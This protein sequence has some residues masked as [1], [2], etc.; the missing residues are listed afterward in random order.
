MKLSYELLSMLFLAGLLAGFI[1]S[2]AGGGG[3]ISLP[4]LLSVG[5]SPQVALGTNK[6]QGT[7]GVFTATINYLRR[8]GV[9][10]KECWL[11]VI[12]TLIGATIGSLTVQRM[13]A[14]F[15]GQLV[16]FLLLAV[17]IYTIFSKNLGLLSREA[18]VNPST[19]FFVFGF[20]LGF[21]D[22][23]F[24]PGTGAFWTA[25]LL[26]LLGYNFTKAVGVTKVMN[27]T[28]NLVALCLFAISGNVNIRAGIVMAI[29]QI[30]G[31]RIGSNMA[32]KRGA[33][34][35]R[36]VFLTIVFIT[37]IRLFY[38]NFFAVGG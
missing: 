17:F 2:I 4:A 37:V 10:L 13:N 3:L 14:E 23:F 28:S 30:I 9:N 29:G 24:G 35:I 18:R 38:Q 32:I 27:F 5:M 12:T 7:C 26:L 31:A 20:C 22:G 36:P 25:S 6:L 15:L 1:D 34:F 11:G 21:Y 19:Y 16:P 8:G 33:R